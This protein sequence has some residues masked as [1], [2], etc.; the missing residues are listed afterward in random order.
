[1]GNIEQELD[2]NFFW[3]IFAS[4]YCGKEVSIINHCVD[5]GNSSAEEMIRKVYPLIKDAGFEITSQKI[6]KILESNLQNSYLMLYTSLNIQK[7]F[8]TR[9]NLFV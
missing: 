7:I 8:L 2:I 3:L 9:E 1:M 6:L 5:P 4:K